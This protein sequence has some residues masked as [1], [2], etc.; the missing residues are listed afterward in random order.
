M[1]RIGILFLAGLAALPAAAQATDVSGL[2][3]VSTTLRQAPVVMD[4]SL[5][6]IGVQ[7]SGWCEPETPDAAP[8]ALTGQLDEKR[9]SWGYDVMDN[10][11]KAHLAYTGTLTDPLAM[12]GQLAVDGI[13]APLMATRR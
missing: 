8:A 1:T 4:C 12:S 13:S 2:W 11:R 5:L 7:L 9:A 10:G 6:Q 3:Q